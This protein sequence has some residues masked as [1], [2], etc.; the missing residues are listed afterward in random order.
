M[1]TFHDVEDT[2]A[3]PAAI[4]RSRKKANAKAGK[5]FFLVFSAASWAF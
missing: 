4:D 2:L 5:D 1:H 3:G